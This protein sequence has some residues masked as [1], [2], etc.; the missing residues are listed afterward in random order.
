MSPTTACR[1]R[2]PSARATAVWG[3]AGVFL[4]AVVSPPLY[5][6]DDGAAVPDP[7][8]NP[9]LERLELSSNQLTGPIPVELGQLT[10]LEW[11]GPGG[12]QREQ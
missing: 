3:L 6:C 5:A 10:G 7:G 1:E 11:L 12:N 9:R 2:S 4:L 8:D